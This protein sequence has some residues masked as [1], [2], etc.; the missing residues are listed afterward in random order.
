MIYYSVYPLP[1]GAIRSA[2]IISLVW[3]V[4]GFAAAAY[5]VRR[6]PDALRLGGRSR[7][8]RRWSPRRTDRDPVW[9]AGARW[10]P[11][12]R[13]GLLLSRWRRSSSR[14]VGN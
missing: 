13:W 2:V 12:P 6:H 14:S 10:Y 1:T 5:Y 8:R 7:G 3:M 11:D 9:P 4:A